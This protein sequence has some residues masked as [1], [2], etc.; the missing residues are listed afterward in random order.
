MLS[1]ATNEGQ[2]LCSLHAAAYDENIPLRQT[3][4]RL[5]LLWPLTLWGD[6]PATLGVQDDVCRFPCCS[7]RSSPDDTLH[8]GVTE[9]IRQYFGEKMARQIRAEVEKRDTS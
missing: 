8:G 6:D 7:R 1:Y 9:T 4:P 5:C 3:K 2:L